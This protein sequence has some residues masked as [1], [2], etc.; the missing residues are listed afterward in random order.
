M[1]PAVAN[2]VRTIDFMSENRD[3]YPALTDDKEYERIRSVEIGYRNH[4]FPYIK[5]GEL[6][7][8]ATVA[9]L[10]NGDIVALVTRLE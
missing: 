4:W 1:P 10:R 7:R 9:A 3:K 8:K 5:T 6:D 2:Q